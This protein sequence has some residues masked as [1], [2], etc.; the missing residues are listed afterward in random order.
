[1]LSKQ[2]K[3]GWSVFKLNSRPWIDPDAAEVEEIADTIKKCPSEVM[4]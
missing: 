3:P 4:L 1:L 2:L